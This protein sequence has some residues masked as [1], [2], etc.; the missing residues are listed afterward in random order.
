[1]WQLSELFAVGAYGL[2]A[3]IANHQR[4]SWSRR[5]KLDWRTAK[6]GRITLLPHIPPRHNGHGTRIL[7]TLLLHLPRGSWMLCQLLPHSCSFSLHSHHWRP[8]SCNPVCWRIRLQHSDKCFFCHNN[9]KKNNIG[10]TRTTTWNLP[11]PSGTRDCIN[12]VNLSH[13]SPLKIALC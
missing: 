9:D 7:Q 5:K 6:W 2:V 10:I 3:G 1:M 13:P 12:I 8:S 11:G 4:G